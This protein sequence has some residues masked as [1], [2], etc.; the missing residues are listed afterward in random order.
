MAGDSLLQSQTKEIFPI[1]SKMCLFVWIGFNIYSIADVVVV[2]ISIW[3]EEGLRIINYVT[4][5]HK[6]NMFQ[7]FFMFAHEY[8]EIQRLKNYTFYV[9]LTSYRLILTWRVYM[10]IDHF[11]LWNFDTFCPFSSNI[12]QLSFFD[13]YELELRLETEFLMMTHE[14]N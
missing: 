5:K 1:N 4:Q 11:G 6:N 7:F 13:S 14:W 8:D 12:T 10:W 3:I 2:L 9:T